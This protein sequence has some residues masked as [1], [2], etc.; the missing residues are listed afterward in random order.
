MTKNIQ[1]LL[2]LSFFLTAKP[3]IFAAPNAASNYTVDRTQS[4]FQFK[5][6]GK[7]TFLKI[8]GGSSDLDG[9]IAVDPATKT[10]SGSIRLNLKEIKTGIQLRDEHLRD[11]YLE[12]QKFPEAVLTLKNIPSTTQKF[13]ALLNL[14][15]VE[16]EVE[17]QLKKSVEFEDSPLAEASFSIDLEDFKI[18]IPSFKGITVAS[19][20]DIEVKLA[21]MNVTQNTET[22][23]RK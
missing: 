11:K 13:L 17:V 8:S 20:V 6:I 19:K 16:K 12:I 14:H 5:A 21:L 3:N 9:N 10:V 22:E 7:P 15:G 18:E 2:I 23:L 1:Q 4:E